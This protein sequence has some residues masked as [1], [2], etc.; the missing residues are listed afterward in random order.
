MKPCACCGTE[1]ANPTYCSRSCAATMNNRGVR[2][3]G[4]APGDCRQCGTRLTNRVSSYCSLAC[5]QD[6]MAEQRIRRWLATGLPGRQSLHGAIREWI[7]IEQN[8]GCAI[9]GREPVWNGAT[10]VF[11]LDH[12]DGDGTNHVRSN[13]RMI[14]PNCDSQLPTFKAR[15]RGNGRH[16]R[17]ERYRAGLSY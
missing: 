15:N 10:L 9:C 12:I 6:G 11:V 2:R 14:C 8:G 4:A 3:N 16:A 1:T 13:V 7:M 5:Y 17:R